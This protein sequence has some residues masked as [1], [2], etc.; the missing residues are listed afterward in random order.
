[1][2]GDERGSCAGVP[3][4]II[5]FK[6]HDGA[7]VVVFIAQD[8]QLAGAVSPKE[9]PFLVSVSPKGAVIDFASSPAWAHPLH[10]PFEGKLRRDGLDDGVDQARPTLVT[11]PRQIGS[12]VAIDSVE[13]SF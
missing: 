11:A 8:E 4:A 3:P 6:A 13:R 9:V 2:S 10:G 1:M 7:G 5:Y 12:V